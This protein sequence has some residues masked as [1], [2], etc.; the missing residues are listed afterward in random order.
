ME[1]STEQCW[2]GDSAADS[3]ACN[4]NS[5]EGIGKLMPI[6]QRT[7]ISPAAPASLR[8]LANSETGAEVSVPKEPAFRRRIGPLK[9][10]SSTHKS[11]RHQLM[12]EPV[13]E[14]SPKGL[15]RALTPSMLKAVKGV[16]IGDTARSEVL[17]APKSSGGFKKLYCKAAFGM[18]YKLLHVSSALLIALNQCLLQRNPVSDLFT[19]RLGSMQAGFLSFSPP[20]HSNRVERSWKR[21]MRSLQC[22]SEPILK[23]QKLP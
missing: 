18:L 9:S 16:D 12:Q 22:H 19:R 1:D 15:D 21:A 5:S 23:A 3:V 8:R 10:P 6:T 17:A 2:S 7:A 11:R 20:S 4:L 13:Q 14:D